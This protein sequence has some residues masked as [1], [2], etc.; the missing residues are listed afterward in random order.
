MAGGPVEL[1]AAPDLFSAI[2]TLVS[3]QKAFNANV[4]AGYVEEGPERPAG[5]GPV[6]QE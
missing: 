5:D 2:V 3:S 4:G 1:I 6:Y